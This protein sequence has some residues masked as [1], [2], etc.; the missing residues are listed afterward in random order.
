MKYFQKKILKLCLFITLLFFIFLIGCPAVGTSD[1]GGS[2]GSGISSTGSIDTETN[3]IMTVEDGFGPENTGAYTSI[4]EQGTNIYISYY[5]ITHGV[6]KL[7]KSEDKGI[8]W[9]IQI[10]DSGSM[11]GRYSSIVVEDSKIYI[12]YYD[13]NNH[14]LKF[15]R[16]ADDGETWKFH[17][18]DSGG[19]V[20]SYTSMVKGGTFGNIYISYYDYTNGDI[21]IAYNTADGREWYGGEISVIAHVGSVDILNKSSVTTD[22]ISD[23]YVAFCIGR[24][25]YCAKS[26]DYGVHWDPADKV[27]VDTAS[28][29][30]SLEHPS[31]AYQDSSIYMSYYDT[32]AGNGRIVFA[33]LIDNSA[34]VLYFDFLVFIDSL[35]GLYGASIQYIPISV[36]GS[37]IYISYKDMIND[38]G[39]PIVG[40]LVFAKSTDYGNT[41]T[42]MTVDYDDNSGAWSDIAVSGSNV[43][44]SY[45]ESNSGSLK[46]AKSVD[47]GET[48]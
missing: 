34:V 28:P 41:W 36:D 32:N 35:I 16:S 3:I 12:S 5:D 38:D 47:R 27:V 42:Y 15:A 26:T 40:N 21:K 44:I 19:D 11:V 18:I 20:G 33:K 13:E 22:G 46:F 14:D 4:A 37:N 9:D 7:A 17:T 31:I 1:D 23:V 30:S 45:R 10:V 2:G 48:W 25:L 39:D 43:Y 6:L 24:E 8:S 29:G